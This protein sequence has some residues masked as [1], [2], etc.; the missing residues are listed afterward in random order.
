MAF[1]SLYHADCSANGA[2]GEAPRRC[3]T[4]WKYTG[5]RIPSL[6]AFPGR[7]H[8]FQDMRLGCRGYGHRLWSNGAYF[9]AMLPISLKLPI[10]GSA[11]FDSKK[12]DV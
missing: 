1:F 9:F 3:F 11:P 5:S 2:A 6:I 10:I 7:A 12:S 4:S 8:R